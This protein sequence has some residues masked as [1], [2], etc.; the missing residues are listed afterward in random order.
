M[1]KKFARLNYYEMLDLKPDAAVFEIRQ[2]YNTALQV[3]QADSLTSYSFF[4]P[5]ERK[6]ILNLL[7]KAYLTLINEKSRRDYDKEL[8]GS[9]L[10]DEIEKKPLVKASVSIFDINRDSGRTVNL[11]NITHGLREKIVGNELIK[12]ILSQEHI[13]GPDLVKIRTELD[14]P[15]EQIAQE[16]KI[17]LDFLHSIEKDDIKAFPAPIFLKG[18]IK[19]YLKCLSLEPADEICRKYMNRNS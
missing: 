11:K 9:G 12:E 6:T 4:S 17:R 16:T 8:I 18:F 7:E 5:D 19:S 3:Y 13:S 1:E 15:L 14:I 2:A 10:I